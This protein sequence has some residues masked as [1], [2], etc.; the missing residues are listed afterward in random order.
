MRPDYTS[1]WNTLVRLQRHLV[2]WLLEHVP[3]VEARRIARQAIAEFVQCA[4]TYWYTENGPFDF[5]VILAFA[6]LQR[7]GRLWDR[8]Q[9]S[10]ARGPS[11]LP[12]QA[13]LDRLCNLYALLYETAYLGNLSWAQREH[14][15]MLIRM[16]DLQEANDGQIRAYLAYADDELDPVRRVVEAMDRHEPATLLVCSASGQLEE[17]E[18]LKSYAWL[19]DAKAREER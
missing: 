13:E 12:D 16:H 1:P 11:L 10:W 2:V 9:M 18:R 3:E 7:T 19:R 15:I 17:E 5:A 4:M 6:H 14:I 8:E